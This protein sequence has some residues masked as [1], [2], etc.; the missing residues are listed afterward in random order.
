MSVLIWRILLE[1]SAPNIQKHHYLLIDKNKGVALNYKLQS[2]SHGDTMLHL[3]TTASL[4]CI[5]NNFFCY[6]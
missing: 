5:F 3:S 1:I 6:K 2:F 4:T